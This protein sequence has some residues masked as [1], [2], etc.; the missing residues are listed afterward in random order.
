MTDVA[1]KLLYGS[2]PFSTLYPSEEVVKE[3][4][5]STFDITE[6]DLA[7]RAKI[8]KEWGPLGEGKQGSLQHFAMKNI[9]DRRGLM[10]SELR[11][12]FYR[13]I[14]HPKPEDDVDGSKIE[15]WKEYL[16]ASY[17]GRPFGEFTFILNMQVL[18]F[19][20]KVGDTLKVCVNVWL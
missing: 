6:E 3:C 4:I 1:T 20:S 19:F 11:N 12:E 8:D 9:R 17:K 2:H 10:T 16:C 15:A 7:T 13:L 5:L 18:I 14:D